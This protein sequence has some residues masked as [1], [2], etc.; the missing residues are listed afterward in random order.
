MQRQGQGEIHARDSIASEQLRGTGPHRTPVPDFV[1]IL[2]RSP[3]LGRVEP[4]LEVGNG[5]RPVPRRTGKSTVP[6]IVSIDARIGAD[7]QNRG[8]PDAARPR[9][10]HL[11][12]I[13]VLAPDD[14]RAPVRAVGSCLGDHGTLR[15]GD[16][17]RTGAFGTVGNVYRCAHNPPMRTT[18]P[19][20]LERQRSVPRSSPP[21]YTAREH[22]A[23]ELPPR[24]PGVAAS[25]G[26]GAP[27][28]RKEHA[29][30]LRLH[31]R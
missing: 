5:V 10:R 11:V 14:A 9:F 30:K 21:R 22:L 4:P 6:A 1:E 26:G 15:D 24:H 17:Q 12:A 28:Q 20:P 29:R 3:A 2:F 7:E 8:V 18:F 25:I 31:P 13:W 27:Q 16:K 19:R 23:R